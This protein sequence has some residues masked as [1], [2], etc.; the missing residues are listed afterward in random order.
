MNTQNI[1]RMMFTQRFIESLRIR[2]RKAMVKAI[3]QKSVKNNNNS[4]ITTIPSYTP[5]NAIPSFTFVLAV[6]N[7]Q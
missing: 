6:S 2:D 5:P 3:S 1:L 7:I 4:S